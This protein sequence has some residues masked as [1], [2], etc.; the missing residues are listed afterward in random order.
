[1]SPLSLSLEQFIF[2][3]SYKKQ[4]DHFSRNL[5]PQSFDEKVSNVHL[6]FE[7]MMDAGLPQPKENMIFNFIYDC[8]VQIFLFNN[9]TLQI[10]MSVPLVVFEM[11]HFSPLPFF[12]F[13]ATNIG[14]I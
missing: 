13:E 12:S 6:A 10:L 1:M 11:L 7:L 2:N 3:F 8:K 5:F 4:K 14:K 9:I